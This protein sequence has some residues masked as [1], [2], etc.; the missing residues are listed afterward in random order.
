MA[1]PVLPV[2]H[3]QPA[4][5]LIAAGSPPVFAPFTDYIRE[6]WINGNIF[7]VSDLSVF[8]METRTNNDVEGYHHRINAKAQRRK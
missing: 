8:M 7:S 6:Q 4:F 3:I 2:E 1:L 5:E